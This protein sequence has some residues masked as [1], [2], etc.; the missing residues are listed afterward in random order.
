MMSKTQARED[1]PAVVVLSG[2]QDSATCLAKAFDTHTEVHTVTFDY[3]QRHGA[4][5]VRAADLIAGIVGVPKERR[6]K[7]RVPFLE[8]NVTSALT[9]SEQDV[10]DQHAYKEGLP[11]SFVPARNALFLTMAHGIAQEVG[12]RTIY[13][14]VCQT[15]YSGYP[16]C[17]EGF[18]GSLEFA[19]NTG[20]ESKIYIATPLMH[21]TKAETF[22][23]ASEHQVLE[24]VLEHTRTCY[25][26]DGKTRH[27]WGYGCD[28]CPA[29]ELRK[30]GFEEYT[31]LV[32][33]E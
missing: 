18:I 2:G 9:D 5:E 25:N 16:D 11:A 20:Y 3:G 14:G 12:A 13:T 24:M 31:A 1:Y 10:S 26:G 4:E 6:Y 28:A 29:C 22:A 33:A 17:R 15:D 32:G 21:L 19:L 8:N 23:L 7:V 27:D 30:K